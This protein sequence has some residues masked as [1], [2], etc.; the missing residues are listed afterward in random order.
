MSD[1]DKLMEKKAERSDMAK[2]VLT[3][4]LCA[5]Q[6]DCKP[7]RDDIEQTIAATVEVLT[8]E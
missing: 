5:I 6:A 7:G 3:I 4:L 8:V 1:H 2:S